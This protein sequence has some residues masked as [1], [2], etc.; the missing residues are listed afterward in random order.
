MNSDFKLGDVFGFDAEANLNDG[1]LDNFD[2]FEFIELA[3]IGSFLSTQEAKVEMDNAMADPSDQVEIPSVAMPEK[4]E[5]KRFKKL[6]EQEMSTIEQSRQSKATKNN[7]KWGV[8]LFQGKTC[9]V[10][11]RLN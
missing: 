10:L 5:T 6:S 4:N 8:K 2:L 11:V 1:T 9:I 3:E 7:T